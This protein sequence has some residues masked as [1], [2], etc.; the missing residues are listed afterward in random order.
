MKVIKENSKVIMPTAFL[1]DKELS[2]A[3]TGFLARLYAEVGDILSGNRD[4]LDPVGHKP[5]NIDAVVAELVA[6]GYMTTD[7]MT[8]TVHEK[9]IQ[10]TEI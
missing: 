2:M 3:A 9:P 10:A 1:W 6:R 5:E 8:Y 4:A 7:G